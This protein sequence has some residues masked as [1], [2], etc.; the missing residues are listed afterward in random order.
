MNIKGLSFIPIIAIVAIFGTYLA[1]TPA[2]TQNNATMMVAPIQAVATGGEW[3]F[4]VAETQGHGSIN[5]VANLTYLGDSNATYTFGA[6]VVLAQIEEANG[7]V[8]W[9]EVTTE[10][11]RL[12][13]VTPGYNETDTTQVPTTELALGQVYTLIVFPQVGGNGLSGRQLE[14][15]FTISE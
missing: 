3:Q 12:Q 13:V 5:V 4:F 14:V 9:S 8:I 15:N 10:L 6:P 11:L 2:S 1:L 7:T